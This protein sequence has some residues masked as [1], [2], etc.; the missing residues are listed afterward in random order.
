MTISAY[1][2]RKMMAMT[3]AAAAMIA[4]LMVGSRRGAFARRPARVP[5][6]ISARLLP[7]PVADPEEEE[8]DDD[9]QGEVHDGHRGRFPD[10]AL[11]QVVHEYRRRVGLIAW[12]AARHLPDD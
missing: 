5:A 4:V 3:Y 12:A 10:I 11:L 8:H 1:G 9:D 2:S 7:A 6:G